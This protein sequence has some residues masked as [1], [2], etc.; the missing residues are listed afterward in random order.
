MRSLRFEI[1]CF[2]RNTFLEKVEWKFYLQIEKITTGQ[3]IVIL[4]H[5]LYFISA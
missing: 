5:R 1:Y 2:N 4:L 3:N